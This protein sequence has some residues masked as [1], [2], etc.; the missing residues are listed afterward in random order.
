MWRDELQILLLRLRLFRGL[1]RSTGPD[2]RGQPRSLKLCFVAEFL[3]RRPTNREDFVQVG[4]SGRGRVIYEWVVQRVH[5]SM[6]RVG[7]TVIADYRQ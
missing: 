4:L 2:V 5:A 6:L 3:N 7:E 1:H